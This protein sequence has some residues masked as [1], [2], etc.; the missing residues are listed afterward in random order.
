MNVVLG[1]SFLGKWEE[2]SWRQPLAWASQRMCLSDERLP[3]DAFQQCCPAPRGWFLKTFS[4][5]ST[6][7]R[8]GG[9]QVLLLISHAAEGSCGFCGLRQGTELGVC[10]GRVLGFDVGGVELDC[11]WILARVHPSGIVVL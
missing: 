5:L 6:N 3:R 7:R 9:D 11:Y 10:S 4:D 1:C 8:G 2:A